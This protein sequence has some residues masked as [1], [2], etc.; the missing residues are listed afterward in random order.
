MKS[1]LATGTTEKLD[2]QTQNIH[3]MLL[4]VALL[5]QSQMAIHA[6][7]IDASTAAFVLLTHTGDFLVVVVH[8]INYHAWERK[9]E[10]GWREL[11]C[12]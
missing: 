12:K 1:I 9:R 6:G 3:T 4:T 7:G 8:R 5:V 10:E 2:N 11:R